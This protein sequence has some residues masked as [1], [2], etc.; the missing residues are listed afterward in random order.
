M[1]TPGEGG[2]ELAAPETEVEEKPVAAETAEPEGEEPEQEQPPEDPEEDFEFGHRTY[3]VPK[4]LKEGFEGWR[5]GATKR[6]QEIAEERKALAREREE[7]S[8]AS[9]EV[10]Q[11]RGQLALAEHMIQ[12]FQ[13][14][15][16]DD[17]EAENPQLAQTQLRKMKQ[18][19]ISRDTL[20][21]E[22]ADAERKSTEDAQRDTATR[23]QQA[24]TELRRDIPNWSNGVGRQVA[25]FAMSDLNYT[26]AELVGMTDA[27]LGKLMH[28]AYLGS[29]LMKKQA[30]AKAAPQPAVAE[31]PIAR[32]DSRAGSPQS[33]RSLADLAKGND[34]EA[35]SK[36]R[37][38]G[39]AA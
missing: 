2:E 35:Y 7:Q 8:K 24:L 32:V 16:W 31:T 33:R 14:L 25:E 22:V 34:M 23:V 10:V 27:R 6:D 20:S 19:E 21:Q 28:Q 13:N 4:S 29:Q 3:K 37:K 5:A 17:L 30:A 15:P 26:A 11:K 38:A 36:A 9:K 1:A 18:W 39:R 12:Q